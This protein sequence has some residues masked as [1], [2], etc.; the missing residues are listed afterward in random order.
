MIT[1][2]A[3][4]WWRITPS[5]CELTA[6]LVDHALSRSALLRPCD[7]Y[8]KELVHLTEDITK[9]HQHCLVPVI[10]YLSSCA[11]LSA[12]IFFFFLNDPPPPEISPLPLPDALPI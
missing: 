7:P 3:S 11:L 10:K 9:A 6:H 1:R 5:L 8:V 2:A 4:V 12:Q